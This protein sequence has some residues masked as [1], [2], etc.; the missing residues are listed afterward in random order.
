MAADKNDATT[1]KKKRTPTKAKA[2]DVEAED[3]GEEA[4]TPRKRKAP[5][6]PVTP[7]RPIPANFEA[8]DEADRMLVKMKDDGLG[9][10]EIRAAWTKA[11]GETPGAS[12]LP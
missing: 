4:V 9:W 8:A 12:T 1:P 11:T 5:S 10:A 6:A 2:E 7:G 3:G